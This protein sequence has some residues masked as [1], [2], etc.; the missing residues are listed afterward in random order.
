MLAGLPLYLYQDKGAKAGRGLDLRRPM[1]RLGKPA[2]VRGRRASEI[3]NAELI[4][5]APVSRLLSKPNADWSGDGIT[6]LT[7]SWLCLAGEAHWRIIYSGPGGTGKP[8]AIEPIKPGRIQPVRRGKDTPTDAPG[9]SIVGWELD[10]RKPGEGGLALNEC[11]WLRYPD[12]EDPDYGTLAPAQVAALGSE[13]YAS[14]LASN[15]DIFK[16]GLRAA[17]AFVPGEEMSAFGWDQAD[18]LTRDVNDLLLGSKNNHRVPVFPFRYDFRA[19]NVTPRDAEFIA[20][21]EFAIEDVARAFRIPIE[22]VGGT[23]R[24]YQSTETADRALWQRCL[25]PEAGWLAQELTNKLLPVF[26]LDDTYFLGFDLSEVVALQEDEDSEWLRD[27]GQ[28]TAGVITVDEWRQGQGLEPFE[29]EAKPLQPAQMTTA[30]SV[31]QLVGMGQISAAQ[32]EALL[33]YAVGLSGEAAKAIIADG[34][35]PMPEEPA[36]DDTAPATA[37]ARP[38]HGRGEHGNLEAHLGHGGAEW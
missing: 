12:P 19:F 16:Q 9:R 7:E 38:A 35:M 18:E 14:A 28:L 3:T 26:G 23:R 22:M 21:M 36:A 33:T 37:S 11:I 20:L 29:A 31:T 30:L 5:D 32:G 13:A 25:A 17:G 27:S 2:T 1:A 34:A 6:R 24:T 10:G 8:I 15:R 4:G